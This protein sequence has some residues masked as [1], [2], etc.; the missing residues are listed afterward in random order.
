MNPGLSETHPSLEY[1]DSDYPSK[2]LSPYPE[3]F[4]ETTKDQGLYRDV[5]RFVELAKETKGPVLELCCGTGRVAIQVA[6]AGFHITA[7]DISAGML[8]QFKKKL[9]AE[10]PDVEIRVN[11]VNQTLSG[12]HRDLFNVISRVLGDSF[13]FPGVFIPGCFFLDI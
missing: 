11:L 4:D 3:N 7:V 10:P 5:D 9:G 13:G 2:D 6:R 12:R 8:S 1:Y